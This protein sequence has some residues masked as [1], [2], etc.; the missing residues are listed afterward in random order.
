MGSKIKMAVFYTLAAIIIFAGQF[1]I[2]DN[3]LEGKPPCFTQQTIAGKNAM[4]MVA[5]G[6]AIIY[7]WA[8]WCGICEMMQS[9]VSGVL[10]EYPGITIAIKSGGVEQVK[11]HMQQQQLNWPVVNDPNGDIAR[12]YGVKA[13]PRL[14]ILNQNGDVALTASGYTSELGIKI[15]IWLLGVF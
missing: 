12:Q 2:T 5:K 11:Q 9:A 13:V 6:P 10:T 4:Q 3:Q 1:L 7:F 14:I 15:R 8:E